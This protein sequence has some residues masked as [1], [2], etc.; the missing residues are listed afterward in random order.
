M[1]EK[2][3]RK[4]EVALGG[5]NEMTMPNID[6]M[7]DD[8]IYNWGRIAGQRGAS[9]MGCKE[10][11]EDLIVW[12]IGFIQGARDSLREVLLADQHI[13]QNVPYTER[14]REPSDPKHN[15]GR[16]VNTRYYPPM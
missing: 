10:T 9:P 6:A 12:M 7:N 11:G 2:P 13:H 3:G 1:E 15:P 16:H 5:V 4:R 8:M 14:P